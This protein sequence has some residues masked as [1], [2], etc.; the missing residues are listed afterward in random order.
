MKLQGPSELDPPMNEDADPTI[1]VI[2]EGGELQF[3]TLALLDRE[4]V[5]LNLLVGADKTKV[6]RYSALS[7]KITKAESALTKLD[8]QIIRAQEADAKIRD[9]IQRRR[10]S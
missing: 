6:K 2:P 4:V 1:S 5:R 10:T 9:L 7:D 3:Q 8:E